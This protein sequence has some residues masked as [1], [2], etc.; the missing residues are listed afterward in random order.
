LLQNIFN[1]Q[2][3][4]FEKNLNN[5]EPFSERPITPR[6]R[7]LD[8]L[9]KLKRIIILSKRIRLA[10][11][12][13]KTVVMLRENQFYSKFY[14][15]PNYFFT[16][17]IDSEKEKNEKNNEKNENKNKKC[18]ECYQKISVVFC[19]VN[20][21]TGLK[22]DFVISGADVHNLHP[23]GISLD[24][25]TKFRREKFGTFLLLNFFVRCSLTEDVIF[26]YLPSVE[27]NVEN[28][29]KQYVNYI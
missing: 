14:S 26:G 6:T 4:P 7:D 18:F 2:N 3:S 1:E 29:G 25:S 9:K 12:N 16:D 27:K 28:S 22:H 8:K 13:F 10:G 15:N 24:L 20:I 19:S 11:Q 21:Y 17:T 23:E 5:P